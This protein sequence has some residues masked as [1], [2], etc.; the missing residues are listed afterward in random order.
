MLDVTT[1]LQRGR[2]PQNGWTSPHSRPAAQSAR[3]LRG[4]PQSLWLWHTRRMHSPT[5]PTSRCAAASAWYSQIFMPKNLRPG[6]RLLNFSPAAQVQSQRVACLHAQV[7]AVASPEGDTLLR[8]WACPAGSI[9]GETEA[10]EHA[11][12]T[13]HQVRSD[14]V[15]A[16]ACHSTLGRTYVLMPQINGQA[17]S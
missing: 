4:A 3:R 11:R 17:T 1:L 10:R 5:R 12:L 2:M 16:Y 15:T 13:G 7:M 8:L 6:A 9:K 14:V